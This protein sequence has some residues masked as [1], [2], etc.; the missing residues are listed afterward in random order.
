MENATA[1]ETSIDL[2][3]SY[4][5]PNTTCPLPSDSEYRLIKRI[6]AAASSQSYVL[7]TI[8][9]LFGLPGS[10]L[11]S[12]TVFRM[13]LKPSTLY[14]RLLSGSDFAALAVASLT[15]YKTLD[16]QRA[17]DW[18]EV[19]KWIG[20]GFQA[21]SHWLLV[22][23]C[24]ERFV[25]VRFPLHKSKLYTMSTA[26]WTC[27]AAM[28][29]SSIPLAL[30]SLHF[31]ETVVHKKF[32]FYYIVVYLSIYAFVPMSLI[33][34]FTS[35][36]AAELKR[37]QGRRRALR[38]AGSNTNGASKMEAD[39]TRMMFLSAIFFVLLILP[40]FLFHSFDRIDDYWL[41]LR[42]CPVHAAIEYIALFTGSSLCFLNHAI[43]FYIYIFGAQGFR[44]QFLLLIHWKD[45]EKEKLHGRTTALSTVS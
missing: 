31:S 26:R 41:H 15:Y 28:F 13:P 5:E 35:L 7:F 21:F 8:A 43:N 23:I 25:S 24:I 44:K 6:C 27:L 12:L 14:I 32:R 17:T 9:L 20:R 39:L 3:C 19:S 36:T 34:A 40:F 1:N 11:T 45:K 2:I 22:L 18:E 29:L 42:F 37:T 10:I 30:F 4:L 33:V 16:M 38:A